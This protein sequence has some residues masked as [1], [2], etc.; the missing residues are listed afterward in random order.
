MSA[1]LHYGCV[2]P[3][4]IALDAMDKGG[5]GAGKFLDELLIWRELSHHFCFH[6]EDL[7]SFDALP[8][9]ARESL[10]QHQADP[11]D[12]T[13]DWESLC[14]AKSGEPLWD[15]AQTSLLRRGELH[16]NV[17]MT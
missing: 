8:D 17:R 7:E 3:F 14:R 13:F 16:N 10:V 11:R 4:Q 12:R 15:L 5:E 6:S 2:S 9:W 1:Y